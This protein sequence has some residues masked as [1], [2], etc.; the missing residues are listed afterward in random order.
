VIVC[1][2][3]CWLCLCGRNAQ[4]LCSL[5]TVCFSFLNLF[6]AF[7]KVDEYLGSLVSLDAFSGNDNKLKGVIRLI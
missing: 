3:F 7:E 1:L 5:D 2:K 6:C 4:N